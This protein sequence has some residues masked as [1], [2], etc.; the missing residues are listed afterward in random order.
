MLRLLG[1]ITKILFFSSHSGGFIN[2]LDI[3]LLF[4]PPSAT[5]ERLIYVRNSYSNRSSRDF[6]SPPKYLIKRNPM[7]GDALLLQCH[8]CCSIAHFIRNYPQEPE[9][10]EKH[11]DKKH[12]PN[13]IEW[14]IFFSWLKWEWLKWECYRMVTFFNVIQISMLHMLLITW[15]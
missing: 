8:I 6:S 5:N 9:N 15:F 2:P 13:F 1:A 3:F 10:L 12:P 4:Q 7:E 11:I 14:A